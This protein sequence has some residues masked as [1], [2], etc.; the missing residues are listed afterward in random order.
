MMLFLALEYIAGFDEWLARY[1][2]MVLLAHL[3][4]H[5]RLCLGLSPL[6]MATWVLTNRECQPLQ[7]E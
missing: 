1:P 2:L 7:R 6:A 4:L 3:V 5:L